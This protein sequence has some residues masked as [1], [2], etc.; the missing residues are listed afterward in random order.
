MHVMWVCIYTHIITYNNSNDVTYIGVGGWGMIKGITL[1]NAV[2]V[3]KCSDVTNIHPPPLSEHKVMCTTHGPFV[4][5]LRYSLDV[6]NI[7]DI[8]IVLTRHHELHFAINTTITQQK[9]WK[10][11]IKYTI[12]KYD[13]GFKSLSCKLVVAK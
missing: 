2:F 5:R 1:Y 9:K 6:V 13:C 10:Y 8:I 3:V 4:V 12:T 7:H 11:G